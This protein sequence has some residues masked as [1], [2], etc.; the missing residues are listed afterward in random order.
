MKLVIFWQGRPFPSEAFGF[1]PD[2]RNI[3]QTPW[4]IFPILP[5]PEKFLDFHPP[6]FLMTFFLFF[7]HRIQI[8]NSPYFPCFTIFPPI[9]RK[10]L[11][12]PYF[13]K[14]APLFSGNLRAFYILYVCFVLP[15]FDHD[16][17]MLHTMRI[18]DA[19]VFWSAVVA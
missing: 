3:S 1:S 12:S 9:S 13:Y 6:K 8:L 19:P 7:S 10:L 11:F 18:L 16:A 17:F 5:F 4:K 15:Y 2:F 14:F